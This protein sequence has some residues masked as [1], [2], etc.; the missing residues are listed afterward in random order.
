MDTPDQAPE[1]NICPAPEK[2]RD[3]VLAN[4]LEIMKWSS[5]TTRAQLAQIES[6]DGLRDFNALDPFSQVGI[7]RDLRHT[8]NDAVE[9]Q[10]IDAMIATI[11]PEEDWHEVEQKLDV[12]IDAQDYPQLL[13]DLRNR[14]I[15]DRHVVAAIC[16]CPD[17][18]VLLE[19][20]PLLARDGVDRSGVEVAK[21]IAQRGSNEEILA[22]LRIFH[23][24]TTSRFLLESGQTT[25]GFGH[26]EIILA[27]ALAERGD[28]ASLRK[29]L[30][31]FYA[32]LPKSMVGPLGAGSWLR[33][34]LIRSLLKRQLAAVPS[35]D[36]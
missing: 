34:G 36:Q 23:P 17:I 2:D 19:A 33:V 4:M 3:W 6:V 22:A 20:L 35:E 28:E 12:A 32:E 5:T 26:E 24:S 11:A 25:R 16:R 31:I 13:E 9:R 15:P 18:S 14:R 29:A 8:T 7:L 27:H 10:R 30:E 21:V 1:K